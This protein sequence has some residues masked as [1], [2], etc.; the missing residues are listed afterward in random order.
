MQTTQLQEKGILSLIYPRLRNIS[1]SVAFLVKD[2]VN[3]LSMILVSIIIA[4]III[5]ESNSWTINDSR[6]RGPLARC[7][8]QAWFDDPHYYIHAGKQSDKG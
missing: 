1:Y 6:G 8:H 7:Y 3:F 4:H 5:I 2:I